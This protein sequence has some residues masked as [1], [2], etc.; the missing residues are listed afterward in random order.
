M[1]IYTRI[2]LI[3]FRALRFLGHFPCGGAVGFRF[4]FVED[5]DE[6]GLFLAA[7]K[8]E[9]GRKPVLTRGFIGIFFAFQQQNDAFSKFWVGHG[10][11]H[12]RNW[13][14]SFSA[15]STCSSVPLP[16]RCWRYCLFVRYGTVLGI[17]LTDVVCGQFLCTNGWCF[18]GQGVF[19]EWNLDSLEG[20]PVEASG[21]F[22]RRRGDV[23]EGFRSFRRC[24]IRHEGNDANSCG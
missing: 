22:S 17:E 8:S 21:P 5:A 20:V 14:R 16:L 18:N 24:S 11:H 10:S 19:R 7:S 2:L 15:F 12:E 4:R 9:A 1:L 6:E 13:Q 23:R 3:S